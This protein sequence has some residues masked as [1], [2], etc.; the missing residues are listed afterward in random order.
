MSNPVLELVTFK[1]KPGIDDAEML[2]ASDEAMPFLQSSA[3]FIRRELFKTGDS[4]WL[5]L[6]YWSSLAEAEAAMA[7]SMNQSCVLDMMRLLDESSMSIQH[8]AQV[9]VYGN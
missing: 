5:D 8:L 3:G 6:V 2:R 7:E 4:Q 1:T 9:R